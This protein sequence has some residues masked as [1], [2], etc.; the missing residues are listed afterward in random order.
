MSRIRDQSAEQRNTNALYKCE[1]IF[2]IIFFKFSSTLPPPTVCQQ[3][4]D[5]YRRLSRQVRL[6]FTLV[7]KRRQRT[8]FALRTDPLN[9]SLKWQLRAL[10]NNRPYDVYPFDA[11]GKNVENHLLIKSFFFIYIYIYVYSLDAN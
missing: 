8:T 2:L 3:L 5:R 11:N 1:L 4:I 6:W 7:S 9:Y 10:L